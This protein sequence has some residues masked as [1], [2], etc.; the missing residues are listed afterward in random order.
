MDVNKEATA[1]RIN[2]DEMAIQDVIKVINERMVNPFIIEES[3]SA[4]N[5]KPLVNMPHLPLFKQRSQ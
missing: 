3:T 1:D 4:D 2:A 5:R